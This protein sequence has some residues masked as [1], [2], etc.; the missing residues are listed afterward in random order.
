[1]KKLLAFLLVCVM[2]ISVMAVFT[3]ASDDKL[4]GS[5]MYFDEA[6]TGLTT[7]TQSKMIR[8]VTVEDGLLKVYFEPTTEISTETGNPV[9]KDPKFSFDFSDEFKEKMAEYPILVI[10]IKTSRAVADNETWD[11]IHLDFYNAEGTKKSGQKIKGDDYVISGLTSTTDWQLLILD[12]SLY[13]NADCEPLKIR[14]DPVGAIH[15]AITFE[16][17]YLA[18]FKNKEAVSGFDGN[19]D[20]LIN[21]GT[22]GTPETPDVP[23][24]K[25]TS[26]PT[27][28]GTA[29]EP[30]QIEGTF[31][32]QFAVGEPFNRLSIPCPSWSN[33]VGSLKWTLYKWNGTYNST[34]SSTAITSYEHVDYPDNATLE[35]KLD[36]PAQAGEYLLVLEN[37]SADANESVGTWCVS[38]TVPAIH[39]YKEGAIFTAKTPKL[40]IDFVGNGTNYFGTLSDAVVDTPNPGT[41]DFG[42]IALVFTAVSTLVLKKKKIEK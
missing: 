25:I 8:E 10:R 27:F 1:M 5:V 17:E 38:G 13:I 20:N 34:I 3:N 18:L 19:L 16:V 35:L 39:C 9:V 14:L 21:P 24:E 37:T 22:P 32:L 41:G 11:G 30:D 29:Q 7:N 4:P 36:T 31:G 42:M 6:P 40:I 12:T 33:N 23:E 26:V 2:A 28:E 15:A